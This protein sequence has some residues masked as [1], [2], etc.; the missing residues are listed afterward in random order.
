MG[1]VECNGCMYSKTLGQQPCNLPPNRNPLCTSQQPHPK[2]TPHPHPH[3]PPPIPTPTY[4]PHHPHHPHHHHP[5]LPSPTPAPTT[6]PHLPSPTPTPQ[7]DLT[8][9]ISKSF[10][11]AHPQPLQPPGASEAHRSPLDGQE[12]LPR[13]RPQGVQVGKH[14]ARRAVQADPCHAAGL[15]MQHVLFLVCFVIGH[16]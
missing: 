15:Q 10:Y 7:P 16:R 1:Q 6:C 13:H 9:S 4:T 5:H 14:T 12:G 2:T 11:N 8:P 3:P